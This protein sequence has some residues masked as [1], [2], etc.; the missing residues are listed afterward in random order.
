MPSYILMF[1]FVIYCYTIITAQLNG[2]TKQTFII[3]HR[4]YPQEP[5]SSLARQWWV[6]LSQEVIS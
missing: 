2:L 3:S 6:R 5:G 1:G 4:F